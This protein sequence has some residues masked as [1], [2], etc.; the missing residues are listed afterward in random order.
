M[1]RGIIDTQWIDLPD[2]VDDAYINGLRTRAGV[3]FSRVLTEIDSR[4]N[5]FNQSIDPFLSLMLAPP[6]D[7]V[8]LPDPTVPTPFAIEEAGEYTIARPQYADEIPA[9]ML[10]IR[11]W[12][13][14]T[15]FTED[16][17]D[18]MP[19]SG[20]LLQADSLLLGMRFHARRQVLARL[21]SN[22]E[23]KVDKKTTATNPGF[24]GSGTGDNVF[25]TR[26]PNGDPLPG[27]YTH[28]V[29]NTAANFLAE[30]RAMRTRLDYWEDGPWDLMVTPAAMTRILALP[31]TDFVP[32]GTALVR[33][34]TGTAEALV[35]PNQYVGV[36]LGDIR[37]WRETINDVSEASGDY[38]VLFKNHG[39]LDSRN[40]LAWRYDPLYGRQAYLR[41]R[42][43]YPLDQAVMVWRFGIGV[44]NRVT[45]AI[46]QI[47]A[48]A[49]AYQVPTITT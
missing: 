18:S 12:D 49:G 33:P 29:R 45:V 39:A 31:A 43:M 15:M 16:G 23:I 36:L 4:L 34:A 19:L 1:P 41:S 6:T 40:A 7:Q 28:Y 35:D 9:P 30:I 47:A 10:P 27:G 14:S 42:S 5:A 38:S 8:T 21:F 37:V 25:S 22:A 32:A 24:A 48:S 11:K 26:L 13:A 46:I 2:A 3:D 17:L 44:V 20:I